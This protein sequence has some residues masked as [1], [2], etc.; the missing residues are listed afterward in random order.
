[1][2][3]QSYQVNSTSHVF[4]LIQGCLMTSCLN[5]GSCLPDN[6]KQTYSCSCQQPWT[7][8]RCQVKKSNK[9]FYLTQIITQTIPPP[10]PPP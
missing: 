6:E 2:Y 1:M 7:G 4:N 9:Q 8:D 10:P 3:N 5:G